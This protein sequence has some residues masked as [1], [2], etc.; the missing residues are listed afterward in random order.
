MGWGWEFWGVWLDGG[1]FLGEDWD[2]FLGFIEGV[3]GLGKDWGKEVFLFGLFKGL[4]LGGGGQ[5]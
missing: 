1:V 2:E 4:I 5:D 3:L